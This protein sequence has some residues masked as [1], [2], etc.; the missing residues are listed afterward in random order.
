MEAVRST[1]H[2]GEAF[3]YPTGLC[4]GVYQS[5]D[6]Q[7][8]VTAALDAGYRSIDTARVYKNEAAVGDA[9]RSAVFVNALQNGPSS[10]GLTLLAQLARNCQQKGR[11]RYFQGQR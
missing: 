3:I 7:A 10:A 2:A 4:F 9:I 11:L 8:S 5:N 1:A 6:A